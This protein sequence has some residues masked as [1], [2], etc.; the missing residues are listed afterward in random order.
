MY[1]LQ[2]CMYVC[3][4]YVWPN[5]NKVNNQLSIN[6]FQLVR[7][8]NLFIQQH[9][10]LM[11]WYEYYLF[12]RLGNTYQYFVCLI[13]IFTHRAIRYVQ[14]YFVD[15]QSTQY[16][17]VVCFIEI[18][19]D[20]S[21]TIRPGYKDYNLSSMLRVSENRLRFARFCSK[22]T[23]LEV[24]LVFWSHAFAFRFSISFKGWQRTSLQLRVSRGG[25]NSLPSTIFK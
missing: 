5:G 15:G 10:V 8:V 14:F 22:L 7:L 13:T 18:I 1:L 12:Y 16:Y 9:L 6:W 11:L 19:F 2:V 3:V 21:L 24:R 4:S 23:N 25:G 17:E 20:T